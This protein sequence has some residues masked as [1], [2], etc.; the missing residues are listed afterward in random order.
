MAKII[1]KVFNANVYLDDTNQVGKALECELP[2]VSDAQTEHQTLG[3]PGKVELWQ[4]VEKMETKFKWAAYHK[5]VLA[6]LSP[7]TANKL[8]VRA[9]QHEYQDSSL[10]ATKQVRAVIVGRVKDRAPST[11]KAG[12][13]DVETTFTVDYYKL[14]IDDVP[15]LEIDLVN[16]IYKVNDVD[17][18]AD[19]RAALGL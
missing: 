5:E 2:K 7:V 8:T 18:Y 11:L 1:R 4:G 10:V 17:I 19:A 14:W 15:V 6:A 12:E 16:Y 9:A 3:M 13:G